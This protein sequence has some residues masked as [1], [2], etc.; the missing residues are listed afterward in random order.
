MTLD[1]TRRI[2]GTEAE[3]QGCGCGCGP[4][5]AGEKED[6]LAAC[7]RAYNDCMGRAGSDLEKAA[8]HANYNK[9]ITDC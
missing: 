9:C 2:E 6:C 4:A 1:D 5:K 3:D 8:C 7:E